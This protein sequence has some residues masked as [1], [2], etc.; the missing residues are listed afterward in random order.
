MTEL[1]AADLAALLWPA[2]LLFLRIGAAAFLMPAIGERSVPVRVRLG[3]AAAF[4]MLLLPVLAEE[5]PPLPGFPGAL[6]AG[7]AEVLT[8]LLFGLMLRL[9][10]M[11]LQVAGTI[12]AQATSISQIFGGGPSVEPQPALGNVLMVGGLALAAILDL[13]LRLVAF[14]VETYRLVPPGSLPA[15]A[16]VAEAGLAVVARI[17]ALAFTLAA[18]FVIASVVY[19]LTLGIINRA[20]PQLMVAFVGAPAITAGA[21][22][23]L[24][25]AGPHMLSV[26]VAALNG[27]LADPGGLGS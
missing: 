10:V 4:T 14:L 18:P 12:A 20:M 3:A 23:L 21:L 1:A 9:F 7:G 2:F 25:V 15:P 6:A 26:W 13:H 19:N 17:F 5:L 11:G 27:F 22:I 24:M 8:G 16:L